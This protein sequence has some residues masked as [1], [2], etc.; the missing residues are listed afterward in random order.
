MK[1]R[2]LENLP[3]SLQ[4]HESSLFRIVRDAIALFQSRFGALRAGMT[5]RSE[6]SNIHDCMVEVAKKLFPDSF[7]FAKN[8][9]TLRVGGHQI[10]LKKH[11]EHLE[12][13]SYPTQMVFDF[14]DQKQIDLFG[15]E[16]STHIHLGYVP[17]SINLANSPVWITCPRAYKKIDW[18]Y[19]LRA[20]AGQAPAPIPPAT[21]PDEP[22]TPSVTPKKLP[23]TGESE[24]TA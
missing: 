22:L 3:S 5:I 20:E 8:L 14:E 10:K 2:V 19:E 12:T 21:I 11:G 17:D 18:V 23:S 15:D 1:Y 6:R 9:F 4:E 16:P 13:S 24:K 7:F